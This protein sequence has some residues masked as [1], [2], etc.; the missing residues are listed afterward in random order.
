M[1]NDHLPLDFRAIYNGFHQP[2][3]AVDCG[4]LCAPHNPSGKPFCCDICF[5]VPV[6]YKQEWEYLV[7]NNSL[8][9]L[10]CGDECAGEMTDP[11][12]LLSQTPENLLLLACK[13]P[14]FCERENRAISC[15]QFPFFPYIT[16]D[17]RFIGLAYDWEFVNKCWILS[18]LHL[19]TSEYLH[20]FVTTYDHL[21]SV[22]LEDLDSYAALSEETREHYASIHK[23]FPVLHRNGN[24]YL[25]SPGTEKMRK[26]ESSKLPQFHPYKDL[27]VIQN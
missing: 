18:N 3:T 27:D 10:W 22:M 1:E 16:S 25:V 6:A 11:G 9:H 14:A 5:A 20:E 26:I 7:Q 21:F 17:F 2:V 12:E 13:G 24:W 8:W 19:V 4:K 23:R 15:R